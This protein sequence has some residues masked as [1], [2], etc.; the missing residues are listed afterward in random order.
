MTVGLDCTGGPS[1]P[2]SEANPDGGEMIKDDGVTVK[3]CSGVHVPATQSTSSGSSTSAL[4]DGCG[5]TIE[6]ISSSNTSFK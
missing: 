6:R 1:S 4:P 5:F 2:M 3:T